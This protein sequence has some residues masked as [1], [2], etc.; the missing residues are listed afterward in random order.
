MEAGRRSFRYV[1]ENGTY[2]ARDDE[3]VNDRD[4]PIDVLHRAL[5]ALESGL[6]MQN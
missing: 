2:S 6:L 3:L 1:C 5:Y 4:Q